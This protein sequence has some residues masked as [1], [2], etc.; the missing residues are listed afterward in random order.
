MKRQTLIVKM[1]MVAVLSFTFTS[2]YYQDDIPDALSGDF[3]GKTWTG[4]IESYYSDRWGLYGDQ[5]RTTLQFN[6]EGH[7]FGTGYEVDY[8]I[9][10]P[11]GNYYYCK[12]TWEVRNGIITLRYA[13]T[14]FMPVYIYEYR[15]SQDYFEGYLDDGTNREIFFRLRAVNN[16]DWNP[17]WGYYYSK[18][19]RSASPGKL[20]FSSNGV[21][22]NGK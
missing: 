16:F 6:A 10:N 13:D 15:L 20:K 11:Y 1:L 19:S 12:F 9:N 3:Y 8:D 14:D 2:C 4:T 22:A 7:S 18:A 17:Y 21:F 5:Y